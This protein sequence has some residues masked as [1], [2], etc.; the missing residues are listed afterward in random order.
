MVLLLCCVGKPRLFYKRVSNTTILLILKNLYYVGKVN[1]LYLYDYIQ[2][3][4]IKIIY[5]RQI[6]LILQKGNLTKITL[7]LH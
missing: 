5:F 7:K 4:K 2:D 3:N 1:V 6:T